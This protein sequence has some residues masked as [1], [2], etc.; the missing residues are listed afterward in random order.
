MEL[1]SQD[2]LATAQG[3]WSKVEAPS[4][5]GRVVVPMESTLQL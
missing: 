1:G 3:C 4:F 2:E 5:I